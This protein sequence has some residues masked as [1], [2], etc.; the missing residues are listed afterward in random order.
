MGSRCGII[1]H[2]GDPS[3]RSVRHVQKIYGTTQKRQGRSNPTIF[4]SLTDAQELL[5]TVSFSLGWWSQLYAWG[6][7][8][9]DDPDSLEGYVL[10]LE[11]SCEE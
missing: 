10:Q 3:G 9:L 8:D 5:T 1:L 11:L 7:V 4:D 6:K 2:E